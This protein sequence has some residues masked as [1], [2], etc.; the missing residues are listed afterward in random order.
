MENIGSLYGEENMHR[1]TRSIFTVVG[2]VMG[3]T[4]TIRTASA[5][6]GTLPPGQLPVLTGEWWQWALSIPASQNPLLDTTGDKCM[7]GQ[8]GPIWFLAGTF[9]GEPT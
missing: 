9:T 1:T 7:V 4:M 8:R 5:E 2:I 3:L 6:P